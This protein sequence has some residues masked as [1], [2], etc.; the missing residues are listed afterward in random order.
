MKNN[1]LSF[2]DIIKSNARTTRIKWIL[3]LLAEEE[4]VLKPEHKTPEFLEGV[5]RIPSS[6]EEEEK[7]E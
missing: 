1:R 5:T 6:K 7:T 2:L 3:P 4:D